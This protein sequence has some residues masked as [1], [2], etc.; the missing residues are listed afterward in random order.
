MIQAKNL[1]FSVMETLTSLE[2]VHSV[3]HVLVTRI[4]LR[5]DESDAL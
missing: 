3:T 5:T 1:V 2:A 4:S